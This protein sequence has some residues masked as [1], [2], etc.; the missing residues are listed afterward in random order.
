MTAAVADGCDRSASPTPI[1]VC[2]G[3]IDVV[4]VEPLRDAGRAIVA[5][6]GLRWLADHQGA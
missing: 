1:V 3:G 6:G 4:A 2:L 5:P